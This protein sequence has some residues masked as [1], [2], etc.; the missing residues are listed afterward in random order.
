MNT[1]HTPDPSPRPDC[2]Q[3]VLQALM[4]LREQMQLLHAELEYIHLMLKLSVRS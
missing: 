3:Q 4:H 1:Q 2:G